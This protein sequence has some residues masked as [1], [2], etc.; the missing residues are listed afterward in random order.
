MN[1]PGRRFDAGPH[2]S[3]LARLLTRSN[4]VA[5]SRFSRATSIR[6][7]T[8]RSEL[9]LVGA[10]RLILTVAHLCGRMF[11]IIRHLVTSSP[12][13]SPDT[14]RN[15]RSASRISSSVSISAARVGSGRVRA[16]VVAL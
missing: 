12:S 15:S 10:I 3:E 4:V 5:A 1:A 14:Q 13:D 11:Y 8:S 9:F 7:W 2:R 16:R 6:S